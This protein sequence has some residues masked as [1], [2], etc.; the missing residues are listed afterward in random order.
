MLSPKWTSFLVSCIKHGRFPFFLSSSHAFTA[1]SERS[2]KVLIFI[3]GLL[4]FLEISSTSKASVIRQR[5]FLLRKPYLF[6]SFSYSESFIAFENSNYPGKPHSFPN[7]SFDIE[8]DRF[9]L[10]TTYEHF[11]EKHQPEINPSHTSAIFLSSF[12]ISPH[13]FPK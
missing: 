12:P 3:R 9:F 1:N 5:H 11:S 4:S 13:H 10:R 2:L 8:E 7:G 6:W